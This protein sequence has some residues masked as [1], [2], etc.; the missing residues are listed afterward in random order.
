MKKKLL[1]LTTFVL[2]SLFITG[3]GGKIVVPTTTTTT[4]K[5]TTVQE[6]WTFDY[7]TD[8]NKLVLNFN[9]VYYMVFNFSGEKVI[10][11]WYIYDFKD[12]ATANAYV[13]VYRA[14]YKDDTNG[15][16]NVYRRGTSVVI[17]FEGS[18]YKDLTRKQIEATFSY[19]KIMY[20]K[21]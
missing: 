14:Q 11:M 8:D 3:C 5:T 15:I 18:Q 7:R 4:T 19:L 17:E 16:K 12:V 1:V 9:D 20:G 21:K 13:A 6:N 10:D 2:L